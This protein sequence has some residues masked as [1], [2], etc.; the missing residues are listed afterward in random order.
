MEQGKSMSRAHQLESIS[1]KPRQQQ[2]KEAQEER[3]LSEEQGPPK[4]GRNAVDDFVKMVRR[5]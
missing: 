2:S 3:E 5:L 1:S 4:T